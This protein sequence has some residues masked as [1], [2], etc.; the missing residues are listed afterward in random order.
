MCVSSDLLSDRTPSYQP[1][2]LRRFNIYI[3]DY[4][5]K[6]GYRNTARELLLEADL[7]PESQP[8]INAKQGL[9]FEYAMRFHE[10]ESSS[11]IPA[12]HLR[13]VQMVERLLGAIYSQEQW[14]WH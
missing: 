12:S 1:C 10:Y 13:L 7:S 3:Y 11:L 9:L 8:P 5:F 2:R 14:H 6:R 4:C